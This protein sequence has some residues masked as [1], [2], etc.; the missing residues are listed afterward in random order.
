MSK[1]TYGDYEYDMSDEDASIDTGS[2]VIYMPS[3][4]H[5]KIF[6]VIQPTYDW[7]TGLYTVDCSTAGTYDPW[8]FS[9]DD[10]D[11]SIPSSTYIVDIGLDENQCV[12]SYAI[13]D[14]NY[15]P[16]WV[17]GNPWLMEHCVL[18]DIK[19]SRIGFAKPKVQQPKSSTAKPTTVQTT[20]KH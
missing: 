9:I 3:E 6:D 7:D 8:V 13:S 12:L 11:Y 1:F 18:F 14:K 5:D 15:S 2:P 10:V 19:G 16:D 4:V 20:K 17:L